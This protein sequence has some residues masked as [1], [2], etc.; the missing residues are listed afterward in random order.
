LAPG[1]AASPPVRSRAVGYAGKIGMP[2]NIAAP[3]SKKGARG[4]NA[5]GRCTESSLAR[6]DGQGS[7]FSRSRPRHGELRGPLPLGGGLRGAAPPPPTGR[8]WSRRRCRIGAGT[9]QP[10]DPAAS[11]GVRQ[12]HRDGSSRAPG[13]RGGHDKP[14]ARV[15]AGRSR[16]AGRT[17]AARRAAGGCLRPTRVILS[18]GR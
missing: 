4:A 5:Q 15:D 1:T 12:R 8:G 11:T 3:A 2:A 18:P 6:P 9:D 14:A 16:G 17:C 13:E 7:E 10:P